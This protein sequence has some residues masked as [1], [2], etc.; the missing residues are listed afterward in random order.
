MQRTPLYE[1]HLRLGA[2]MVDFGGWA[3]P[4]STRAASST[5]T[6]RCARRWGSS[7]SRHMGEIHFRGSRAA[8]AVQQLVT[9]DVGRLSRRARALHLACLP[10]GG[11]VDD[12]IVYRIAR[13]HA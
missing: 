4:V 12:L 10:T 7:T 5:S 1:A 3:M 13:R 11:I 6:A 2:K 9:N 8:E